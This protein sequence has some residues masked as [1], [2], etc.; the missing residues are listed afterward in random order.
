MLLVP[1]PKI[2]THHLSSQ[3]WMFF[4]G[5]PSFYSKPFD[6]SRLPSLQKPPGVRSYLLKKAIMSLTFIRISY[7]K[8]S[9]LFS[10]RSRLDDVRLWGDR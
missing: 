3:L 8:L 10:N 1:H 4:F 9:Q 2:V 6:S 5:G 7:H